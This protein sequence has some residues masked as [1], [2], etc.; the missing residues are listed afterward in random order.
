MSFIRR[1]HLGGRRIAA[2]EKLKESE[3]RRIIVRIS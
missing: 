1:N 2:P 3:M